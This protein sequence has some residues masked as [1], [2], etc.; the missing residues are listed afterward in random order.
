MVPQ[1]CTSSR[2]MRDLGLYDLDA[3]NVVR[4]H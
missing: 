1:F 4:L 3:M 2:K